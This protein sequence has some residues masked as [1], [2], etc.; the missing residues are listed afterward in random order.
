MQ[1]LS[2]RTQ[3]LA[4][5]A[6]AGVGLA[7]FFSR[8]MSD[9]N[10]PFGWFGMCLFVAAT[11][12]CVDAVHRI[13]QSEAEATI[14][15]GEWQAWVGVAFISAAIAAS[16]LSIAAFMPQLPIGSNPEAGNAG[17]GIGAIFV[18]WL[19]L[20][21]V[22]KER[23]VGKVLADERDTQID[24]IASQWARGATSCC[25]IVVALLLGF[26]DTERVREFSYPFIA[27][28]LMLALLA[29]LWFDQFVAAILYWRDRRGAAA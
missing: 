29:G 17:R 19:V 27:Q 10:L 18:A 22:L 4:C 26:G 11:W 7:L 12:F 15:H 20:S 28:M 3:L 5:L 13:P 9:L 24:L 16:L 25:V 8:E 6:L 23:W 21:Y 14:A 2:A 1:K